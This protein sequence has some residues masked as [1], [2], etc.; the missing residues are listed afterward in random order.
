MIGAL[1]PLLLTLVARADTPTVTAYG[2]P[3]ARTNQ[4][5]CA[6]VEDQAD[7]LIP[8]R[9][10]VCAAVDG[11]IYLRTLG[12][13]EFYHGVGHWIQARTE[14]RPA[15]NVAVNLRTIFYSGSIS[16]GY[17][18]PIGFY[19]LLGFSA[20]WPDEFLGG[21]MS[22]RVMDLGR[23]TIATGLLLQEHE[24]AGLA[25]EWRR[26]DWTIK[27]LG[28]GTGGLLLADDLKN[29]ELNWKEGALGIGFTEWTEGNRGNPPFRHP[30]KYLYSS[31]TWN[32]VWSTAI[33][34]NTRNSALAAL[35]RVSFLWE[36][37]RW[38]LFARLEGRR[39]EEGW[40]DQFVQR[41]EHMY[42]SYDQYDKRVMST[43]NILTVDDDVDAG[44]IDLNLSFRL[45]EKYEFQML[46]EGV[47]FNYRKHEQKN[48]FFYRW[49]VAYKPD[50]DD[51]EA[52][53]FFVSNKV[54]ADSLSLPPFLDSSQNIVQFKAV[55]FFGAEARFRF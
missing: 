8:Q 31:I 28:D 52:L 18:R 23:Q 29:Y 7:R 22:A 53:L 40:G 19:N 16:Y 9:D 14:V 38:K 54:L 49:G 21:H 44:S 17:T 42:T 45:G 55:P 43:A 24:T 12:S 47:T 27:A 25:F 6:E 33:E 26:G 20:T 51:H 13:E 50:P 11:D 3:A 39:L 4:N 2:Y 30:A 35:A 34:L 46:N 10:W 1:F 41:I 15:P 48:F 36:A 5:L 37:E 32:D